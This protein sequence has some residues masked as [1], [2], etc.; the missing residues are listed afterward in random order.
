MFILLLEY[1]APLDAVDRVREAHMVWIREQFEA[2]RF[3]ASGPKLPRT[4]GVILARDMPRDEL[5]AVIASDPFTTAGVAAYDVVAFAATTTAADAQ[6]LREP[7]P[8][9]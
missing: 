8:P 2:G 6:A 4:G 5:D 3:V 1:T 9:A 7:A